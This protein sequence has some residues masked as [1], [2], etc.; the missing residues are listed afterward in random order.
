MTTYR[1]QTIDVNG[2]KHLDLIEEADRDHFVRSSEMS[3]ASVEIDLED[4]HGWSTIDAEVL[5]AASDHRA[6][7]AWGAPADW[8]DAGSIED[9]IERY[10]NINSKEMA[11]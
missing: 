1:T 6:G 9:A 5:F 4:G 2:L 11:E 8:T 10:L 7:I 3:A